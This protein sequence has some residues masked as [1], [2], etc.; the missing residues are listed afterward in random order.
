M[1]EKPR[2]T[3]PV[4]VDA[5]LFDLAN[6]PGENASDTFRRLY[7]DSE[8]LKSG[9]SNGDGLSG[10]ER[11]ELET[12]RRKV[13][14]LTPLSD[15][16][17]AAMK[18]KII[19]TQWT[20]WDVLMALPKGYLS[21]KGGQ[22]PHRRVREALGTLVRKGLVRVEERAGDDFENLYYTCQ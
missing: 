3:K 11:H 18:G 8:K 5:K 20:A 2:T 17:L 1:S 9:V 13:L 4:R 19:G 16:I 12:L 6:R 21:K 10:N 15:H 7:H 22:Y 14:L